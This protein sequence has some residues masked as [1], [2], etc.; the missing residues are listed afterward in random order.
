[1]EAGFIAICSLEL[2]G[3]IGLGVIYG[4][5]KRENGEDESHHS[6]KRHR[7]ALAMS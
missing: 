3:F 5:L 4:H 1:M 7:E 2:D 6:L